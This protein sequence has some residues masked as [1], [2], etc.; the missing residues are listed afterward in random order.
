MTEFFSGEIFPDYIFWL[1]FMNGTWLLV[2]LC[3]LFY[4]ILDSAQTLELME[5]IAGVFGKPLKNKEDDF[6]EEDDEADDEEND[7][8]KEQT[9]DVSC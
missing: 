9:E 7:E 8:E 4:F 2:F 1:F 5:K 6:E 3:F